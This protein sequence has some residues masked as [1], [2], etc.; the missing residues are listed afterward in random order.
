MTQNQM[1]NPSPST[2]KKSLSPQ[3]LSL[4]PPLNPQIKFPEISKDS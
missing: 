1:K 4:S 2:P 3:K